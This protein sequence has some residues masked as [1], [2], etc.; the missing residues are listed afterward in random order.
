[1]SEARINA[2]NVPQWQKPILQAL[3]VYGGYIG[4]TGGG[5]RPGFK[6]EG[7]EGYTSFGYPDPWNTLGANLGLP[8]NANG[9]YIFD[10]SKA[11]DWHNLRVALP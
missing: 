5:G 9:D 11:V 4:D 3:R 2:L 7:A 1:M 10:M 6:V 8:T